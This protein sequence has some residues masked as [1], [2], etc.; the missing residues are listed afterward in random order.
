M[1]VIPYAFLPGFRLIDGSQLNADFAALAQSSNIGAGVSYFVNETIGSDGGNGGQDP[2]RPLA[3]I[4]AALA[5]ERTALAK[6]PTSL[7]SVGRNS[8]V[9]FW[10]TIHLTASISWNVPGTHLAGLCAPERRG[11]RARLSVTGSTGFNKL[12]DVTAQGCYFGNFGTF[13]GWVDS[14]ASLLAWSDTA[15]R[16]CYD[17]VEFLGFGDD[18]VTTGTANLTGARAFYFSSSNGETTWRNCVFGVD[19]KVRNATN[20]TLEIAGAAPRLTFE[21]CEFEAYL[22][23]SGGSSSHVLIGASGIDRYV[24]FARCRFHASGSSG[25]TAMAQAFNVSSTAGGTVLLDQSTASRGVTALQTTPTSTMQMNMVASTT[26]GGIS[27]V[28]F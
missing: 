2:N 16:N 5:L 21:S 12:V 3:T 19:T 15:G 1:A 13:F 17:N 28:V 24:D 8:V 6:Y 11:K 18:T 10:G 25:A 27:H 4:A 23:A 9:Y 20:Y 22:G 7:A 26:T 14:A